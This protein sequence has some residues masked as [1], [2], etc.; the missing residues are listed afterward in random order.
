VELDPVPLSEVQPDVAPALD[1]IVRR[2]L[3]KDPS[4][5]YGTTQEI[6]A[7][8]ERLREEMTAGRSSGGKRHFAP[9]MRRSR[10]QQWLVVHQIAVSA[11]YVAMLVPAWM[12]RQWLAQ[13]W[14]RV[15]LLT[16]LAMVAAATSLRLH[17]WF[18]AAA[19]PRQLAA[20]HARTWRWT[21]L[22]DAGLALIFI[23]AAAALGD[24]HPAFAMLFLGVAVAVAVASFVIEPSTA[25]AAFE[26][27]ADEP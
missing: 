15:F 8:L 14:S 3:Q 21:R 18:T 13:P 22:C 27:L 24:S 26:R 17:L 1:R 7:D 5:R 25:R 12:A 11:V 9:L 2:C 20:Q 6:V 10:A 23:A 19:F 16:T 4:D